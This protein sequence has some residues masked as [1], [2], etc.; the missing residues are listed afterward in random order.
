[1][2]DIGC[3]SGGQ[4]IAASHW[5]DRLVG[6]DA[7]MTELALG[8]RQLLDRGFDRATL[9]AANGETLP[10]P[11]ACIDTILMRDVIEHLDDQP[12]A[13][14]E[15]W[16]VLRPGGR[17]LFTSPNRYALWWPEP[18]V[19]LYGVGFLPR[20]WANRYTLWR[21]NMH[22]IGNRLLGLGELRSFLRRLEPRPPA[23]LLRAANPPGAD[24]PREVRWAWR[25]LRSAKI[26]NL[27]GVRTFAPEHHVLLIKPP[28]PAVG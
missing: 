1:V 18:H 17:F 16:R 5:A 22:Y 28:A 7:A 10:L 2:L 9:L 3:G 6:I 20:A 27:P 14:Q 26:C 8:R 23:E 13:L 4:L 21:K 24:P 11:D 19:W 12:G 15:A 25:V